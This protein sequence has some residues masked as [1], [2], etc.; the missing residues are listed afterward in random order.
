MI[1]LCLHNH[2][3]KKT[4]FALFFVF[5]TFPSVGQS[6]IEKEKRVDDEFSTPIA[7]P[8]NFL[9]NYSG[10]LNISDNSGS[11]SNVPTEFSITKSNDEDVFMYQF[12]FIQG[13]EKIINK[14][15]LH[16]IDD[17]NGYYAISDDKG[18]EFMATLIKD[19]LYSTYETKNTIMFTSFQFTNEGKLRFNIII[20]KK[21]KNKGKGDT[22]LSNVVQVQK[23]LL[24][25]I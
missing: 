11:I 14:Y 5:I 22:N 4:F 6:N 8:Y 23:A 25:K 17:N 2:I 19:T 10:N 3:I 1:L 13:K 21:S 15:M 12:S 16:I 24:S 7:F 9:G 20:S 18:L